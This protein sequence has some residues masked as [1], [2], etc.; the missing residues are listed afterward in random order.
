MSVE[1]GPVPL[2]TG[3]GS[4]VVDPLAGV[5]TT[6]ALGGAVSTVKVFALEAGEVL[7]ATVWVTEAVCDP[8]ARAA[9][10]V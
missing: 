8:S 7:P 4:V 9:V 1:A 3:V 6:G 2:R 5:T 10:G